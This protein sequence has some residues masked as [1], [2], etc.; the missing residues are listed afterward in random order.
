MAGPDGFLKGTV[1]RILVARLQI[2]TNQIEKPENY[3]GLQIGLLH[4]LDLDL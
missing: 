3:G 2:A 4:D 1:C